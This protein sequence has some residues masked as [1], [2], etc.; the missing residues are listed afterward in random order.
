MI[1]D[2]WLDE[3]V[4]L[5]KGRVEE[6]PLTFDPQHEIWIKWENHQ[7]TGSY[8]IRGA[9][10]KIL[11]LEPWERERGL[12]TASAGNHGQGVAVAARASGAPVVVFASAHAVPAKLDAMRALGADVRLVPG[13]YQLAEETARRFAIEQEMTFVSPY[14][15]GRVIAGQG[16]I[17]VETLAQ[18]GGRPTPSWLVPA[19]GGG[20][21]SGIGKSL[22]PISPRPTLVGV[23]SVASAYLHEIYHHHSQSDVVELDS[24]ADGL[25]GPV[26]ENS[27]TIPMVHQYV[28]RF[29]LVTETEIEHA[30]AYAWYRH[31][32]IIEGSAAVALALGITSEEIER[33]AVVV[34]TGG[35]IQPEVHAG[36]CERWENLYC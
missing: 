36:I 9:F 32:E 5:L 28:S 4:E 30:I 12:V 25:S 22:E 19:G 34:I 31:H 21:I 33:P 29:L 10:N 7:I 24:L 3:A 26:E 1:P 20:L 18:L 15:D 6:T 14:N 17:G 35:N 27:I 23:Q 8:K 11:N 16:T 2:A 13:G